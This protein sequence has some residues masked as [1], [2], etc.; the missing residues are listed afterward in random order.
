MRRE[1]GGGLLR[2]AVSLR[3]CF[4]MLV[5]CFLMLVLWCWQL[6]RE[7]VEAASA[8]CDLFLRFPKLDVPF[9]MLAVY[10]DVS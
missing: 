6:E 2:L 10:P 7:R 3:L 8:G 1:L 4:L 9:S 5:L